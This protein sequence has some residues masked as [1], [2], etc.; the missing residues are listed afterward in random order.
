MI[1]WAN[2]TWQAIF[3]AFLLHPISRQIIIKICTHISRQLTGEAHDLISSVGQFS[4]QTSHFIRLSLL[5]CGRAVHRWRAWHKW[6][7]TSM[8]CKKYFNWTLLSGVNDNFSLHTFVILLGICQS[9]SG[10]MCRRKQAREAT[11]WCWLWACRLTPINDATLCTHGK[12]IIWLW[13]YIWRST[14]HRWKHFLRFCWSWMRVK[15]NSFN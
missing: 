15:E 7:L 10:V 2:G 1:I 4:L 9:V 12:T 3:F 14:Q 6:D 13:L 5:L 11:R 8:H